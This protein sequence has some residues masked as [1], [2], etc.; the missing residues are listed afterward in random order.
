[1]TPGIPL[2]YMNRSVMIMEPLSK[3]S[4]KYS[5]TVEK[6]KLTGGLN[7]A[8]IGLAQDQVN[9]EPKG[10]KRKGPKGPNPLSVKKKKKND[11]EQTQP[12]KTKRKRTHKKKTDHNEENGHNE[13]NEHNSHESN[14]VDNQ[15]KTDDETTKIEKHKVDGETTKVD[16]ET[17]SVEEP[18][19]D[20]VN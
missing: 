11:D 2:I 5:E 3:A 19:E 12:E 4:A 20:E 8:K 14:G 18:K 17:T 1:M 16:G 7:D 9:E 13:E 6:Q 15:P 10:K